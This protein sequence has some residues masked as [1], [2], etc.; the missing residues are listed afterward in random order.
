MF[1]NSSSKQQESDL[2]SNI[3]FIAC[4]ICNNKSNR[5]TQTQM[6]AL[7]AAVKQYTEFVGNYEDFF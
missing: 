2:I 7:R 6:N 1:G 3:I 5:P 4:E